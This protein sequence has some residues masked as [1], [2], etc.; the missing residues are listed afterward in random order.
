MLHK[1]GYQKKKQTYQQV[2][3]FDWSIFFSKFCYYNGIMLISLKI[4]N[5]YLFL[6]FFEIYS[7]SL[8]LESFGK[9]V[10]TLWI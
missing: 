2:K 1:Y 8:D 3:E 6:Q 5:N 9:T 7:K 4:T 10:N